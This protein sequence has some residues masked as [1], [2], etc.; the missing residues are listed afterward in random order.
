M[1]L[2]PGTHPAT[3]DFVLSLPATAYSYIQIPAVRCCR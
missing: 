3:Q 1:K 2:V